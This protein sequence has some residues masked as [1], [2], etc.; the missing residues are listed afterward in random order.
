MKSVLKKAASW[1]QGIKEPTSEDS[2]LFVLSFGELVI[3]YLC[4]EKGKWVF[5]YS[6]EFKQQDDVKPIVNFPSPDRVYRSE[7]LWPFFTLRIPSLDQ[8]SVKRLLGDHRKEPPGEV[9][10]LKTFGRR[11]AANPFELQVR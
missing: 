1:L 10:M 7:Y 9:E 3:G 2:P 5:E 8:P 4:R 6:K 11:T